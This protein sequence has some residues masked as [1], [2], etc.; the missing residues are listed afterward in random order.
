MSI[1]HIACPVDGSEQAGRAVQVAAELARDI[2][3]RLTL[4]SVREVIVDR[5]ALS[6]SSLPEDVD[7][8]LAAAEGLARTAGCADITTVHLH[9]TD[10]ADL[11]AE[12]ASANGVGLM[13][14]GCKMKSVL[15]RLALGST[16]MDFIRQSSCPVTLV[17]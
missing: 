5:S 15:Q 11:L 3:A 7:A 1:K 9:G 6:G 13:V 16:I 14:M 8:R 10:V 4:L 2:Q 12:Y 17:Q